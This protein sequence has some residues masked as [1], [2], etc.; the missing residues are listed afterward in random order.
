MAHPDPMSDDQLPPGDETIITPR[1]GTSS[2]SGG[3][4]GSGSGVRTFLG[5]KP[6]DRIGTMIGPY[7]V[8]AI[9][10][11]GGFGVVYMAERREPFVQRVAL[12][13]IRPGRED[14]EVIARF[15]AER[16][17]LALMDHPNIARVLD[18][19]MTEDGR[20]YFV[21][22]YVPGLPI[23]AYCDQNRLDVKE[24]L[25]LF[26]GVCEAVQHA[27]M[28]A[29]IHRDLKPDNILVEVVDD[30]PVAKVIDFGIAK[31]VTAWA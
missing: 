1:T 7:K 21:M 2:G 10:G 4:S 22:E 30:R 31:A 26:I 17:T 28:R 3:N 13:V 25:R 27:H 24:R 15:E 16:Q 29:I 11:Q 8:Q 14:E 12:K 9:R 5:F 6:E 19:G 23:T 18:G 20:P